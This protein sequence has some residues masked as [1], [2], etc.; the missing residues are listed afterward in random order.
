MRVFVAGID[1][2]TQG[3]R[4]IVADDAGNI[5]ARAERIFP[6]AAA[7]RSQVAGHREQDPGEWW[8]SVKI[9]VGDVLAAIRMKGYTAADVVA[10]SVSS[11]SG[12]VSAVTEQGE[13]RTP[14]IMYNDARADAEAVMCNHVLGDL[15]SRM[16]Y[17]FSTSF[18]LPKM[19]WLSRHGKDLRGCR[20]VHAADFIVGK[21]T[22]RYDVTD[23]ANALKS[24]YDLVR[25]EWP[26]A[27]ERELGLDIAQL[28][29]VVP[30]GTLIDYVSHSVA[31]ELGLSA[32]TFVIAGMT[33]GV[34]SQIAAGAVK[35][36]DWNSTLGTTLVIKGVT[37]EL[38]VDSKQRL[39]SHRHPMGWWILGGASNTGGEAIE[40]R[41]GRSQLVKLDEQ[42][43]TVAP[44]GIVLYP[45]E[46][47]GERFPFMASRAERFQL[48]TPANEV[49]D[50]AAHLEGVAYVERLSYDVIRELGVATSD[51]ILASGGGAKSRVWLQIRADVLQRTFVP[52]L[53]VDGAMGSA[54]NAAS[55]S[56][57][58]DLLEAV[59]HMV[60]YGAPVEPRIETAGRYDELYGRFV[61]EL[62]GRGYVR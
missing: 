43:P 12:T 33:D 41:F 51:V 58:G 46:R 19:V 21:L 15:A 37:E 38:V 55:A 26:P 10:L 9:C 40:R 35:L 42:V 14:A 53:R 50:Y 57:F 13:L 60:S 1:V 5:M 31:R 39:Y 18:G 34:A 27:L 44:S 29:K 22:G 48:G 7:T 11:T 28:P 25:K 47:T 8:N 17:R 49:E 16:G 59:S 30:S 3:V 62:E 52:A 4:M 2:G 32:R 54:I 23:E 45:L 61:G 56:V 20:Y 24:G 36:G 6:L